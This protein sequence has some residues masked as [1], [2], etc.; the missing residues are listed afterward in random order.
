VIVKLLMSVNGSVDKA[1]SY[2]QNRQKWLRDLQE[3]SDG[4]KMGGIAQ[5]VG[6]K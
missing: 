2:T 6:P 1:I 5:E 4:R 3:A